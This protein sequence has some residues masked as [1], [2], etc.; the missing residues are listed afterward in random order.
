MDDGSGPILIGLVWYTT[1]DSATDTTMRKSNEEI[2]VRY[3]FEQVGK[4]TWRHFKIV[5][6][7]KSKCANNCKYKVHD[8][9]GNK[10]VACCWEKHGEESANYQQK[11][12]HTVWSNI[13]PVRWVPSPAHS[14]KT[15]LLIMVLLRLTDQPTHQTWT[16]SRVCGVIAKIKMR[17]SW[18]NNTDKLTTA[19]KASI[20]P[21]LCHKAIASMPRQLDTEIHAKGAMTKFWGH[22]LT[23]S[24]EGGHFCVITNFLI[25]LM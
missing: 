11:G 9:V 13:K 25:G 20:T 18:P 23:C 5:T 21:Q 24:S 1:L 14:D 19:I 2:K 4:V 16:P 7:P 17:E 10:T 6:G 12:S 8:T 15:G 22:K 3:W